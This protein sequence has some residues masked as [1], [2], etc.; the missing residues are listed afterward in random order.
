MR[1][2]EKMKHVTKHIEDSYY[3]VSLDLEE[4]K[5]SQCG[6]DFFW[7]V[8]KHGTTLIPSPHIFMEGS[9]FNLMAKEF[10]SR[11][12]IRIYFI[13]L[14]K[15]ENKTIQGGDIRVVTDLPELLKKYTG[16]PAQIVGKL[17][18]KN[19]KEVIETIDYTPHF[20]EVFLEQTAVMREEVESIH[21]KKVIF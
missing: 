7:F 1:L 2:K 10:S 17:I 20:Y 14:E 6:T 4:M 16:K 3:D 8:R 12:A 9:V 15:G 13:S 11:E 19:G 18:L 21:I 5:R